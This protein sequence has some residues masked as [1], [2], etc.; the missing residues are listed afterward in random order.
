MG[1]SSS[2][3]ELSRLGVMQEIPFGRMDYRLGEKGTVLK[4]PVQQA[5]IT[6]TYTP[7]LSVQEGFLKEEAGS[8][9]PGVTA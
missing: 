2:P 8:F 7:G 6:H 1:R 3:R 9:L 4:L 5:A